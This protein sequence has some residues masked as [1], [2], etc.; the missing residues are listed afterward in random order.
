M[1]VYKLQKKML[2]FNALSD[3]KAAVCFLGLAVFGSLVKRVQ[4]RL[5]LSDFFFRKK[6]KTRR[7]ST[8]VVV[9]VQQ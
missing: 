1:E 4:T 8:L 9:A 2:L 3:L 7:T 5:Y 6:K